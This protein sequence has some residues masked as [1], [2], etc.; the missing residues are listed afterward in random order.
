MS[1]ER[2]VLLLLLLRTERSSDRLSRRAA[3]AFC[4]AS[5]RARMSV[6]P[7]VADRE[8][9][10]AVPGAVCCR[11]AVDRRAASIRDFKSE[12]EVDRVPR[13]ILGA[14]GFFVSG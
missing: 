10:G 4:A 5:M 7:A 3:D 8:V 1:A 6:C 9:F 11:P 2:L 13:S 14:L 12:D